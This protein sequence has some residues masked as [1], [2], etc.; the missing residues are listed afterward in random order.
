MKKGI[1]SLVGIITILTLTFGVHSPV[2][3]QKASDVPSQYAHGNHG[4]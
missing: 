4:G 3:K 2:E 1:S